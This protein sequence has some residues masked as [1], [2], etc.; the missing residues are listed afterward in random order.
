VSRAFTGVDAEPP[1]QRP[2]RPHSAVVSFPW[3]TAPD[4][5][6][7][8][9]HKSARRS[10][11]PDQAIGSC[12]ISS[13]QAVRPSADGLGAEAPFADFG[14]HELRATET[15]TRSVPVTA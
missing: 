2:A 11:L 9:P 13:A 7:D 14:S 5:Q 1:Q 10:H 8:L 15:T 12:S 4:G 3:R 6:P